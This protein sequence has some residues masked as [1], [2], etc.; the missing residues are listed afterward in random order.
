MSCGE[1]WKERRNVGIVE[2][3]TVSAET[4]WLSSERTNVVGPD[5]QHLV[6]DQDD[7]FAQE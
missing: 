5:E 6:L 7:F 2:E 1:H 3:E 4:G